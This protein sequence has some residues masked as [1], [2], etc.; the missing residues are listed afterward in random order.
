MLPGNRTKARQ[1]IKL[2]AYTLL[3]V[4]AVG[5]LLSAFIIGGPHETAFIGLAGGAFVAALGMGVLLMR[6]EIRGR[7]RERAIRFSAAG[8]PRR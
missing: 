7:Y 4:A 5:C 2:A 8:D 6:E 1:M 3:D